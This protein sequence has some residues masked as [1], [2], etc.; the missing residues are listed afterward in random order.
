MSNNTG[1]PC[2]VIPCGGGK[3]VI[4]AEMVRQTMQAWPSARVLLLAHV[5]ELIDQ[6]QETMRAHWPGA[7]LGVY[8]AGLKK[9]ELG[10]P[11]TFASMQSVRNRPESLGHID[12]CL[13][14]EAHA[15]SHENQ[16]T[17]RKLLAELTAVNPKMR[18]VGLSGTP[19]RMGHGLITEGDALFDTLLDPVSIEQLI[20]L[21]HLAPLSSKLTGLRY[22]TSAVKTRGGEYIEGD[23]ARAVDTDDQNDAVVRETIALAGDR[24]RWMGFCTGVLHAA[25]VRDSLVGHGVAAELVTG[26][27]PTAERSRIVSWFK[28]PGDDVRALISINTMTTGFNAPDTD[29]IMMM[30]P[31]LSPGLYYQAVARGMRVK[32]HTDHCL[33]LDFAGVVERH[34]PI[35]AVATPDKVSSS[36]NGEAPSKVCDSCHEIVAAATRKCPTCGTEFPEPEKAPLELHDD[37]IMATET[38]EMEIESW[39][40][41]KHVSRNSGK[42]MLKVEYYGTCLDDPAIQEYLCLRHEGYAL[43]KA[44]RELAAICENTNLELSH[45]DDLDAMAG[46]LNG[47]QPPEKMAYKKDGKF[48]RVLAKT[49]GPPRPVDYDEL[50]DGDDCPF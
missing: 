12:L 39:S 47:A 19:Y 44:K 13:V 22:D 10:Q 48:W 27:T 5:S 40:W 15:I 14:D 32:S 46:L 33:V 25:H 6:A 9:R 16:G 21:G 23:L 42:E 37:D 30:R 1:H 45:E 43:G 49:W 17:Y 38:R 18:V 26:E 31:T 2:L 24:K 34:G 4:I 41:C 3:T 11:I 28:A 35:T 29:L 8:A 50:F 20:Y 7:P 36:G